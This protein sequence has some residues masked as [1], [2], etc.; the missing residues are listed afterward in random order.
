MF[1]YFFNILVFMKIFFYIL[2]ANIL[3]FEL[4]VILFYKK[5]YICGYFEF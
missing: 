2:K 4:I 3:L 5:N 1:S